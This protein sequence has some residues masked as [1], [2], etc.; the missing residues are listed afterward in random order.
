[1][2][3]SWN[4]A[5]ERFYQAP[6]LALKAFCEWAGKRLPT[7]VQRSMESRRVQAEWENAARGKRKELGP[8]PKHV[9]S[10]DLL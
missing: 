10:T 6:S 8:R 4:D 9:R 7:E 3:I 5:K 1:M 2:H